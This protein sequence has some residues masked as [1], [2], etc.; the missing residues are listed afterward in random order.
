MNHIKN[1]LVSP[2]SEW[3]VIAGEPADVAS[4]YTGY[5]I[6]LSAIPAVCGLIGVAVI[7]VAGF[8]VPFGGALWSTIVHYVLGL[9][10]VYVLALIVSKLAPTF[11]GREDQIQALKLV[12]YSATAS[13]V[14]GIFLII[15]FLGILSLIMSIYSLY[16]L[17][18]GTS[19]MMQVPQD[20][21]VGYTVAVIVL[22]I[23][24]AIVVGV[25][26]GLLVGH[27]I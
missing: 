17:Y 14:G 16:I 23:L 4:L 13:W 10:G 15:P 6:P 2:R 25:L 22:A 1:I 9:V 26:G 21:A 20:R 11:G 24:A 18:L 3:P 5:V 19:V 7:G 27:V 8:R 12:A